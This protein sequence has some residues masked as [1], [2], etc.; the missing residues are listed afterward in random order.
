MRNQ[1]FSQ[2]RL[3][4][5]RALKMVHQVHLRSRRM[6]SHCWKI[7]SISLAPRNSRRRTKSKLKS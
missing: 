6:Q 5:H 4:Y 7:T 3:Q 2:Q 1:K